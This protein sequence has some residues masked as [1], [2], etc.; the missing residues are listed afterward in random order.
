VAEVLTTTRSPGSSRSGSSANVWWLIPPVRRR[1]TSSR[2][3]SRL[4][5]E[6]HDAVSQKLFSIRAKA[7]AASV[8]V[9]RDPQRAVAE[10]ESVAALTGEAHTELRAVIDGL[11]PAT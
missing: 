1:L 7:A 4:A 5:R 11:A 3:A 8:L 2:T 6:L 10:M 9:G